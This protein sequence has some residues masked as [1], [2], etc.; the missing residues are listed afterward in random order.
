MKGQ[1]YTVDNCA[2]LRNFCIMTLIMNWLMETLAANITSTFMVIS[3]IFIIT[4]GIVHKLHMI[5]TQFL[6]NIN[7]ENENTTV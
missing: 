4:L 3:F 2:T 5:F 1:E 7:D 6:K